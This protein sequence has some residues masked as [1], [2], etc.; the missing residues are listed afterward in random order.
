MCKTFL[1]IILLIIVTSILINHKKS[2]YNIFGSIKKMFIRLLS[3]SGS[4]A[5]MVNVSSLTICISLNIQPCMARPNLTDLNYKEYNQALHCYPFMINFDRC[6]GICKTLNGLLIVCV[7]N[8]T[9][10]KLT[11]FLHYYRNK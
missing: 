2:Q 9:T 7:T 8:K 3:F 11:C 5:C 4:M 1:L 6:V 10:F